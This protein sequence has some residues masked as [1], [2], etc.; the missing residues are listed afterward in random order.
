VTFF[1]AFLGVCRHGE[2]KNTTQIFLQKVYKKSMSKNI[3]KKTT[4]LQSLMP[5]PLDFSQRWEF[6]NTTKNFGTKSLSKSF[7]NKTD[8]NPKPNFLGFVLSCFWVFLGAGSSKTPKKNTPFFCVALSFFLASDPPTYNGGHRLF[9]FAAP[10]P[11]PR[12]CAC[13]WQSLSPPRALGGL[14]G[15]GLFFLRPLALRPAA[16]CACP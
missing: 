15:H 10:C 2:F 16:P 12:R 7:Y 8:K 14:R 9:F 3:Y 11:A 1:S 6:K 5:V 13:A 4:K